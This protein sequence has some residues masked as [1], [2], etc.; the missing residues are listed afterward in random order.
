MKCPKCGRK[1]I[2]DQKH[3]FCLFCGYMDDGTI[4][5]GKSE[6][7][8]VSDVEIYLGKKYDKIYRNDTNLIIFL[9]GPFY[10]CYLKHLFLGVFCFFLNILIYYFVGSFTYQYR[11]LFF[12][13]TFLFL[14]VIYMTIANMIYL[15][16]CDRKMK[17]I[18]LTS[19]DNY[20][21]ELRQLSDHTC[22]F[23][24]VIW[25]ILIIILIITFVFLIY[26]ITK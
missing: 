17:K 9:L 23:W 4:I 5:K 22:S 12:I 26:M 19:S 3:T 6:E 25:G 14:R 7:S 21:D 18:K 16:L 1:M 13:A 2:H 11:F 24:N 15:K 8:K 20:L 10:F